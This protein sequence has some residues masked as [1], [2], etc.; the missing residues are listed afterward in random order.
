MSPILLRK[1]TA[2][3]ALSLLLV[4]STFLSPVRAQPLPA[5][6]VDLSRLEALEWREV[7]PYRG[8]RSCA[9]AGIPEQPLVYYLGSAGGGVWK[10]TDGARSWK[11]VSD[12]FFGGSIGSVAVSEW[13]SN[14]VYVGTGEKTV[15]GNVSHGDG[16]YRSTDAGRTW[17]H[18]GLADSRHVCRLRIHPRNSDLVYAAAL[19]HLFGPNEERGVFRSRDGGQSWEKVLYVNENAGAVD[20][21]MDP[22]N[23][24]I[25]YASFWRIRRTPWSLESGGEGSGLWK[26][27]DGGDTWTELS[28]NEGLPKSPLGII[29]ITVSP[30]NPDNL[31]AII[32]AEAGGVFRSRDA[33]KTWKKTNED[34][35]LRQR[36]WYYSRIYADPAD[37]EALWVL[38]V[39]FQRSK[40]GG[41]TFTSVSTP[42]SDNHD[43][44]IDPGNPL[45]MIESNDGGANVTTDG[46]ENWTDQ[47]GQPTAQMYRVSVD[48]DFPYR[49]LGGQQDN[50]A[51]RIASR[52]F[53]GSGIGPRDWEPTAG[54]ESGHVVAKP[55]EPDIVFGGSYG[56]YLTRI[57]HDSGQQ[58]AVNVWPDNPMGWGAAELAYRFQWN[59]PIFFSPHDPGVL[60]AAANVLFRSRDQG[61]SWE[62]ISP[63]L[64]RDDKDKQ[65]SSGGPITK[66]NTSVEYYCTI[67]ATLES[68]LEKGVLWAGS[69]DG[70]VHVSRDDGKNWTNVTPP[71]LPEWSQINSIEAHPF[72]KG[73]LYLAAT[74]YKLDDFRPYLYRTTDY[75]AT[76]TR[77]VSGI[78]EDH[79]T[80]AVRADPDRKGLLYAGTER[81]VYVSFDD[82]AS[83][84]SLQQKLPLV[85][86]TDLA[87]KEKN[88]VVATQ[89]RGYW[90]LDD[91]S[92]L[93][94]LSTE[95]IAAKAHLFTPAVT[96]RVAGRRDES[97]RGQ[98]KNPHFGAVFH[99]L[100]ADELDPA[101]EVKL[102]IV[103]AGGATIRTFLREPDKDAKKDEKKGEDDDRSEKKLAAKKGLNRFV[104]DL[105]YPG[106][107]SF[108]GMVLWNGRVAGPRAVPGLY[109][110]R[111]TVGDQMQEVAFEVVEDPRSNATPRDLEEQFRF[112]IS[113]RDKLT[114]T[115]KAI[116]TIRSLRKQTGALKGRVD[117]D[118]ERTRPLRDAV[119]SL[120]EK[121]ESI[122]EALY[123]TK[124]RSRQ[125]P[126][127]F[128]IRLNDK[129][130]G[131]LSVAGYGDGRPTRQSEQ[132]RDEL[133]H[134]IDEE[135]GKLR[136]VLEDDLVTVNRL[137]AELGVE[138]VK[139][140]RE[141]DEN[142]DEVSPGSGN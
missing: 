135:L 59:Y 21:V 117:K 84:T 109:R 52:S 96:M 80:R 32:E 93:H 29:G 122:E 100:L 102:E 41:K 45:R 42:H 44:W 16:V 69:D 132:V 87:V 104:W 86:V 90:I 33:G 107:E 48:N 53:Q 75:G 1:G 15:R 36:A 49:L 136:A 115:H 92:L 83:W 73:G 129:L 133:V 27:T 114:E 113:V 62:T 79:F 55:D 106:A 58:R 138:A 14:V 23:P 78:A 61:A 38:N 20:L 131:L 111:F 85:P 19:G 97:P 134:A 50:S 72:E 118:D 65:G 10:T 34:R 126:L 5:S 56:G 60:Y 28:S 139:V 4:L 99:Y 26:T 82:G 47:D 12:G 108:P 137:A 81:G 112:L 37:E 11:N 124:N 77:I 98:G 128:P 7:G 24:R 40:D 89:G 70:L 95:V 127:N 17:K 142:K 18:I 120:L 71:D 119:A 121:T 35:S 68:P 43:L 22:T 25:L 105:R 3:P 101:V 130:A 6:D 140:S 8:G 2:L 125:D 54:G 67:F 31:Y 88:L 64:T 74:R 103:E 39:Q 94:Q 57:D 91:L 110:A 51:L 76:W 141:E 66:D 123:Q 46:G 13:D 63:D 9:V 116:G 30:T